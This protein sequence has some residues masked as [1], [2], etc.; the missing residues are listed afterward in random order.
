MTPPQPLRPDGRTGWPCGRARASRWRGQVALRVHTVRTAAEMAV[1]PC[2]TPVP[3]LFPWKQLSPK[4]PT[5]EIRKI[6]GPYYP[7]AVSHGGAGGGGGGQ[8]LRGSPCS[9]SRREGSEGREIWFSLAASVRSPVA[10]NGPLI[11]AGGGIFPGPSE[12]CFV[13]FSYKTGQ[14]LLAYISLNDT[15]IG[16][17]PNLLTSKV[18]SQGRQEGHRRPFGFID[19]EVLLKMLCFL[20]V[21]A[22]PNKKA[23]Q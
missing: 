13:L 21:C 20:E 2:L 22:R 4:S 1:S 7:K 15:G 14:V 11:L 10:L 6:R 8:A 16:Q 3:F 19:S 12:F 18:N 5:P 9:C 17:H 23:G